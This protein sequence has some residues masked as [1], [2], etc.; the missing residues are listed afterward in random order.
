L[1]TTQ[2]AAPA[3]PAAAKPPVQTAAA[4]APSAA[5]PVPANT[6]APSAPHS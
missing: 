6:Q 2:H 5:A 4:P 3:A 1:G